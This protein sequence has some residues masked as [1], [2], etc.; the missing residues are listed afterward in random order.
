MFGKDALPTR[1]WQFS[2]MPPIEGR[3]VFEQQ[4]YLAHKYTNTLRQLEL[5][6]REECRLVIRRFDPALADLQDRLVPLQEE[7]QAIQDELNRA[8]KVA[9]KKV[10][11]S[12]ETA[13]RLKEIR[14]EI[15]EITTQEKPLRLQTYARQDVKDAL[16][17]VQTQDLERRRNARKHCGVYWGTYLQVEAAAQ[18]FRSGPPPQ[19]R[20]YSGRG[21]IAVQHQGGIT[22]QDALAGK[23]TRFR[24]RLDKKVMSHENGPNPRTR[25]QATVWMRADSDGR[26]PVWVVVPCMIHR[27]PPPGAR[28]KWCYLH[29]DLM[30]ARL[31]KYKDKDKD[32]RE[33]EIWRP[34]GHEIQYSPDRGQSGATELR[35]TGSTERWT[36]TVVLSHED[37]TVWTPPGQVA[38]ECGTIAI[39]LGFR[40]VRDGLRVAFWVDDKGESGA[41]QLPMSFVERWKFGFKLQSTIDQNFNTMIEKMQGFLDGNDQAP[42][43][44][45]T[46]TETIGQWRSAGRMIDLYCQWLE[47]RFEGDQEIFRELEDW[48]LQHYHL[49]QWRTHEA[50]QL[51]AFRQAV[52]RSWAAQLRRK[53]GTV[54]LEK[55]NWREML[56]KAQV[57]V[58]DD[59]TDAMVATQ[60]EQARIAS[61]G[62]LSMALKASMART[63][64]V[65]S[66]DTTKTCHLCGHLN[67][68]DQ[69]AEVNHTCTNCA[70]RWDQ[71]KNAAANLLIAGQRLIRSGGADP[72]DNGPHTVDP[73]APNAV[74]SPETEEAVV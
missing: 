12:G 54:C 1:N 57:H 65:P 44:L 33:I 73:D 21:R 45:K 16:K 63:I 19:F 38:A 49:I 66:F 17:E 26:D 41:L 31:R 23:N 34:E 48:R 56:C 59:E 68:W 55:I 5:Q 2:A 43:W 70:K 64:F 6:R 20:S 40:L 4:S 13:K 27:L 3:D 71:D 7:K 25:W 46:A 28:I 24:I 74:G 47:H 50:D 18:A 60:R 39:D 9:R 10:L 52:Y 51:R 67:E 15:K 22:W 69:A 29:R 8:S 35:P 62:E 30:G 14:A 32:G 58:A 36:L 53:Y 11:A 42:E 72:D 37:G 61:P